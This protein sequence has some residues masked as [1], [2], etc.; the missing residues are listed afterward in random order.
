MIQLPGESTVRLEDPRPEEKAARWA[1]FSSARTL[2]VRMAMWLQL[3][4]LRV[5]SARSAFVFRKGPDSAGVSRVAHWGEDTEPAEAE[6]SARQ[7]LTRGITLIRSVGRRFH[8]IAQP[9]QYSDW[10]IV[11][12]CDPVQPRELQAGLDELRWGAGWL[13]ASVEQVAGRDTAILAR[14]LGTATRAVEV[15]GQGRE[16]VSAA[17][18]LAECLVDAF[19][20]ALVSVG[21]FRH[22]VLSLGARRGDEAGTGN[23]EMDT[24]RE[25]LVRAAIDQG[26]VLMASALPEVAPALDLTVTP[27][28]GPR[29]CA[30]PLAGTA[31]CAGVLLC[32]RS[33][34]PAFTAEELATL[35]QV[36]LLVGPIVELK[37]VSRAAGVNRERRALVGLFGK[38]RFKAKLA[39]VA[40]LAAVLVLLGA[41]GE[42][43]APVSVTV[44]GTPPRKIAAPFDGKLA[45]VMVRTGDTVRRGQVIARMDDS[46]LQLERVK[47][48]A[49]RDR[50]AQLARDL[51]DADGA[52]SSE[53]LAAKR[54]DIEIRLAVIDERL[55]RL[56]IV[57]PLEGIVQTA[58]MAGGP[59]LAVQG[60]QPLFSIALLD[61]YRLLIEASSADQELLREGQ[62]GLARFPASGT[63]VPFT[64]T[65]ITGQDTGS[66][67][68]E[69]QTQRVNTEVGPGA[70]GE[71]VIDFG[72]RK[73][74]WIWW[75]KLQSDVRG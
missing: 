23:E 30:L 66:V 71:G 46:E 34:G 26:R 15:C 69:A 16:V 9:D 10:V 20:S 13:V 5:P 74:V 56:Q 55:S 18:A 33:A 60:D 40:L 31:G 67:R 36:A 22:E 8:L 1:A 24:R 54:K 42:Y 52:G 14:R 61:G 17:I 25:A 57:S 50:L 3:L 35:E 58:P 63:A 41:T 37:P 39:L 49:E 68:V 38:A 75:R 43:Q 27:E 59:R 6:H 4:A 64:I 12:E 65:K 2:D 53:S 47:L 7:G 45:E 11:F 19:P 70:Q 48:V 62:T 51:K 28:L 72:T 44:E 32:E 29:V 21:I 73:Q